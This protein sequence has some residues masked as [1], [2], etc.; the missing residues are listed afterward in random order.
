MGKNDQSTLEGHVSGQSN[1]PLTKPAHAL[2]FSAV[3]EELGCDTE[4]GLSTTKAEELHQ[5]WGNNDL[6]EG[7]GVQPGKIL[8]R[9]VAYAA[10]QQ[11]SSKLSLTIP[12]MR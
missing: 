9:Q 11:L 8:L 2:P 4:D 5:Q 1:K 12:V 6:G 10:L 3:V 7:G